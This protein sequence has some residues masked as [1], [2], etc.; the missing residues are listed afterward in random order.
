MKVKNV[1]VLDV[2]SAAHLEAFLIKQGLLFFA[3][4]QC[5]RCVQ[6]RARAIA[7]LMPK[8]VREI[9]LNIIIMI[10]VIVTIIIIDT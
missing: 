3:C 8:P 6:R 10:I 4:L 7:R 5:F 9:T 2:R 1:V